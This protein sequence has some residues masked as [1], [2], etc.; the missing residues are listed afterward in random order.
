LLEYSNR[1]I[2]TQPTICPSKAATMSHKRKRGN[3]EGEEGGGAGTKLKTPTNGDPASMLSTSLP[4]T[5][6][7]EELANLHYP[8][9]TFATDPVTFADLNLASK[10]AQAINAMGFTELTPIQRKAIPPILAGRDVLGAAKTGSGKTLAFLIPAVELLHSLR[11]KTRNGTG[12][13]IVSPTRELALQ[14]FGVA[15]EL[16]A[17][18][19]QV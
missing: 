7:G 3:E 11:F 18:H 8:L 6:E 13:L 4:G 10:T 2:Q 14:M 12:V 16:M 9:S 19:S 17:H 1:H 15:R 5:N